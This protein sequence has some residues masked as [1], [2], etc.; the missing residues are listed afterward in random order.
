M[1]NKQ[2]AIDLGT[3]NTTVAVIGEGIVYEEPTVIAI[4][5]KNKEIIAIG[6]D[7]KKMLGKVSD[8][9]AAECPLNAGVIANYRLTEKYLTHSIAYANGGRIPK[10][11]KPD[12]TVSVPAGVTTVEERAVIEA[13]MNS[14]AGKVFL[15]PEPIAAALG[16]GMEIGSSDGHMIVNIGGGTCEIAVISVNTICCFK[17]EKYAGN[18]LNHKIQQFIR[19]HYNVVI[20]DQLA[21]IIK[22]QVGSAL[23][24][25]EP[26]V[27]EFRGREAQ[28]GTP[29]NIRIDSNVIAEAVRPGLQLIVHSIQEVLMKSPPELASAVIDRG[30][31][32]AGG[33]ANLRNIGEYFSREV[34]IPA[35]TADDP[36][37]CV[38]TG[39]MIVAE[40][41]HIFRRVIKTS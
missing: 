20:G 7:A 9:I 19:K 36:S 6:S 16:A 32:L 34:G 1:F 41:H 5:K 30:M 13:C 33:T 10:F 39:L 23:P 14:G 24:L 27:M 15:F 31:V 17:S 37:H 12:I 26:Y 2:F 18:F 4:A 8:E 3:S 40:N 29:M 28:T 21:E 22:M 35:H 38:I 25:S 11:F